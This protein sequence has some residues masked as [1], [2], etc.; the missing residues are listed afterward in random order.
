[1]VVS[2]VLLTWVGRADAETL[3]AAEADVSDETSATSQDDVAA[4]VA[5]V[6]A[7]RLESLY[8]D[9][10]VFADDTDRMEELIARAGIDALASIS[11][12]DGSSGQDVIY[13]GQLEK[14]NGTSWQ[15]YGRGICVWAYDVFQPGCRGTTLRAVK[16]WP[17]A[18]AYPLGLRGDPASS[19][20]AGDRIYPAAPW[21]SGAPTGLDCHPGSASTFNC[22]TSYRISAPAADARFSIVGDG[23]LIGVGAADR[24]LGWDN[25]DAA[26]GFGDMIWGNG[27]ADVIWGDYHMSTDTGSDMIFGDDGDDYLYGGECQAATEED[28]DGGNGND[29]IAATGCSGCVTP[30]SA[31]CPRAIIGGPG[32]DRL[33]GGNGDDWISGGTGDD[34]GT[35]Y[36]VAG[37]PGFKWITGCGGA[38]ELWGGDGRDFLHG[39]APGY[40]Y[41]DGTNV[42]RSYNAAAPSGSEV[43]A[44]GDRDDYLYGDSVSTSLTCNGGSQL[45]G[46]YCDPSPLCDVRT[47]CE[48]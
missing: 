23:G 36:D 12:L 25:P 1:M 14:W 26:G 45:A 43:L 17:D 22:G 39:S 46:D 3:W 9:F 21:T 24:I 40:G 19:N 37:V 6:Q 32:N 41:T 31:A 20:Y 30:A 44:G 28:L 10:D 33:N 18:D 48:Y 13:F 38:D 35:E 2:C 11:W 16:K 15:P 5:E 47:S 27:G 42:L 34:K 8:E 29:W 4:W 7:E